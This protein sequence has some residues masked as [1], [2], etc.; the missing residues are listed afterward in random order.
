MIKPGEC[1][2]VPDGVVGICVQ[3][4]NTD[5]SCTEFQKCCSNGCGTICVD[6][7]PGTLPKQEETD[8]FEYVPFED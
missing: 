4:C 2:A 3:Q 6:P 5:E 8:F 1:P 7:T